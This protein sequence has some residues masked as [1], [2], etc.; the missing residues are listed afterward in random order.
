[1]L[2]RHYHCQQQMSM[3]RIHAIT[4]YNISVFAFEKLLSLLFFIPYVCIY[5]P[6][7]CIVHKCKRTPIAICIDNP[8]TIYTIN[9]ISFYLVIENVELQNIFNFY[10][11]TQ[12]LHTIAI[13]IIFIRLYVF[14]CFLSKFYTLFN[15][16]KF[17]FT[18]K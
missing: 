5:L 13:I 4:Y 6:T 3:I 14:D 18:F 12:Q 15:T 9:L 11:C 16:L 1:M 8:K 10:V 17:K 7:W 2:C